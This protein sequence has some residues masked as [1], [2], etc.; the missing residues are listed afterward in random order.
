ML[1]YINMR[2]VSLNS[3]KQISMKLQLYLSQCT[4]MTK[5]LEEHLLL[6]FSYIPALVL[7]FFLFSALP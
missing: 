2:Y 1:K 5:L 7:V 6:R 4:I 3:W